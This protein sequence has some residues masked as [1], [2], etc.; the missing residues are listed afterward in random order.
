MSKK[1]QD[2]TVA[3]FGN[4]WTIYKKNESYYGSADC[5]RDI[6]GDLCSTD[7]VA[8][9]KII[10]IGSGSGRIVQMLLDCEA[11]HVI[12]VEPSKAMDV[13]KENLASLSS[14]ITPLQ[15]T[16]EKIPS[17]LQADMVVSLGVLHHIP[18]P[19]PVVQAASK[20]LKPGGKILVW[21]YAQE[22]NELY[23]LTF[24]ILRKITTKLS[25][26]TLLSLAA[27]LN[28]ALDPYLFLCKHFPMPLRKYFLNHIARL[29]REQRELTIFDQLNPAYAKYYTKTEAL[30]LLK[31]NGFK[32]LK[33]FHRHG[34]S[35]TVFGEKE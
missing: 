32:D 18:E 15:I 35:W 16:G 10:D 13:L 19:Y 25:D 12:A 14:R 3:D 1:L 30:N 6:F 29:N 22:G 11:E 4:Q 33:I 34:Y 9:K 23:L 24:G 20:A 5:L 26:K 21:L 2:A 17:D 28:L 27:M 31:L 8:G 7:F